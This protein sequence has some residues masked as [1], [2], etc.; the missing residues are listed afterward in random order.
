MKSIVDDLTGKRELKKNS[1]DWFDADE[2]TDIVEKLYEDRNETK[3]KKKTSFAPSK[4]FYKKGVGVCP[5]YWFY[6]FNGT[7]FEEKHDAQTQS[8]FDTGISV[9]EDLQELFVEGGICVEE[10]LEVE[11]DDPPIFGYMDNI[12]EFNGHEVPLELKSARSEAFGYYQKARKPA[13]YHTL[14]LLVYMYILDYKVGACVY[15]NK[16]DGEL[17][18]LPVIMHKAN[19]DRVETAFEWMRVVKEA[20]DNEQLPKR[21]FRKNSKR[22]DGCPV[23]AA[24]DE[25]PN[26]GDINIDPL[27]K[28][29][30][31]L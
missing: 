17:L 13:G 21:R 22:C 11:H 30:W 8:N 20:A 25:A 14:Q 16:N 18:T 9:H 27:Y 26:K 29:E 5:R 12:V 23:A 15:K 24:C 4:L 10:E 7:T 6:A 28:G 2:F 1:F 19:K 31:S 3:E